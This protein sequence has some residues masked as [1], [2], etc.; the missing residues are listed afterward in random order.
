MKKFL[1]LLL[2]SLFSFSAFAVETNKD[3][4]E[5]E[6]ITEA[7]KN[8][9]NQAIKQLKKMIDTNDSAAIEY[10]ILQSIYHPI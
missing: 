2:M 10:L 3:Y 7:I 6:K 9:P 8:N 4:N 5:Y 1:I